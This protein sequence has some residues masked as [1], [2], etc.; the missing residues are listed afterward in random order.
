MSE[1]NLS[2]DDQLAELVGKFKAIPVANYI[3]P[4]RHVYF[5]DV[6]TP[7]GYK[8]QTHIINYYWTGKKPEK[9]EPTYWIT[10]NEMHLAKL[11]AN[12]IFHGHTEEEEVCRAWHF[13]H[14]D[15][16]KPTGAESPKWLKAFYKKWPYLK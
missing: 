4:I 1:L 14:V 7:V 12:H 15:T 8:W 3:Q 11:Y 9:I 16:F 10:D 5:V 13:C 2:F 6:L